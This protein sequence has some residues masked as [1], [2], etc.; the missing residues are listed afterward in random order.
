M[1]CT[2]RRC[3]VSR[4][5]CHSKIPA[6]HRRAINVTKCPSLNRSAGMRLILV[7][8]KE[9]PVVAAVDVASER[10]KNAAPQRLRSGNK[11][12]FMEIIQLAWSPC[13]KVLMTSQRIFGNW[14]TPKAFA[15]RCSGGCVSPEI[16]LPSA[17]VEWAPRNRN[18]SEFNGD[19][20]PS[21]F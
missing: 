7:K 18:F 11:L 16:R 1:V 5:K 10:T 12:G 3:G 8:A 9:D 14:A 15:S 13:Q 17:R 19:P 20:F 21:H 4:K 6:K 2:S